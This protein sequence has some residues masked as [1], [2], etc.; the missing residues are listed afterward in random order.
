[1]IVLAGAAVV[2]MMK[3]IT[4]Q[5]C[6]DYTV[7]V[8]LPFV[9]KQLGQATQVDVICDQYLKSS[10]KAHIRKSR[11]KGIR[12]RVDPSTKLSSNWEQFLRVDEN[13][14]RAV[15]L[16]DKAFRHHTN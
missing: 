3:P 1:M 9:Q 12:R 11:G 4:C 15:F 5:T 8:F 10:L 2:I 13:K 16:C 6:E 14:K 7:K